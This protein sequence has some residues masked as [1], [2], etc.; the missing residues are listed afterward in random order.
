MSFKPGFGHAL[1]KPLPPG[2]S[3]LRQTA[4]K[5]GQ[6]F[7]LVLN[8]EHVAMTRG[9]SQGCPLPG[10]Q[11]STGISDGIVGVKPLRLGIQ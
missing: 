10:P 5:I 9:V 7:A 2:G 4:Q 8:V 11:S 1:F 6:R 3:P